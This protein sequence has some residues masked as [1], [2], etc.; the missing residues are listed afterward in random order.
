MRSINE[1]TTLTLL[2]GPPGCGKSTYAN[3]Y[4][5]EIGESAVILSS[6]TIRKELFGDENCQDNP[7]LVFETM[8]TRARNELFNGKH[9][10]WDATNMT[11][12]NRAS[13]ISCK[14]ADT[15]V[16]VIIVWNPLEKIIEQDLTRKRIVGKDVIM[17]MLRNFQF[18]YY[19]E[20]IDDI[21]IYKTSTFN[22]N[23]MDKTDISQDN[24]HHTLT[25]KD[26][27]LK[28]W[29]YALDN[30]MSYEVCIAACLH[31]CGK[32]ETKSFTDVKG[33]P[34]DIAHYYGH[35]GVSAWK[36]T[37]SDFNYF[38]LWLISNHMEPYFNSKYYKNLPQWMKKELDDL[39][40]A[41]EF[42]H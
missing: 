5:N 30:K 29:K 19:D 21:K 16:E 4:A 33:N 20:G 15:K 24:P 34:T 42:A 39:H 35:Q 32:V 26:H 12:K 10:I 17:R 38:I 3:K 14:T 11:R 40:K 9:V 7:G 41:D 37:G 22:V 36:A 23:P 27:C 1:R 13:A 31:D 2:I 8:R 18:P 25:I 28:A 6:D